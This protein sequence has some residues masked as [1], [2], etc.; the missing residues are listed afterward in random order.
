MHYKTEEL[1]KDKWDRR[2]KR[3]NWD[4]LIFKFSMQNL[5]TEEHLREFDSMELPGK[6]FMFVNN[7]NSEYDCAFY[8]PGFEQEA[9]VYNDTF[10]LNRWF[11]VTAFING[12]GLHS[13]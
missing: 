4:N 6:K 5:C 1:A 8:Y 2:V 3:V 13:R 7:P 11:D 9:Q 12:D 10:Y